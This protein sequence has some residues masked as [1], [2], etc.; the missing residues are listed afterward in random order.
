MAQEALETPPDRRSRAQ[1]TGNA[2]SGGAPVFVRKRHAMALRRRAM[3]SAPTHVT[4][5]PL[6]QTATGSE[7]AGMVPT[8]TLVDRTRRQGPR[9]AAPHTD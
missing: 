7:I 3:P 1:V 9:G 4:G 8:A 5:L 2:A 6:A